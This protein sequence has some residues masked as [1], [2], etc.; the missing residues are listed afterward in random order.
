MFYNVINNSVK[1]TT[2]GEEVNV[3]SSLKHGVFSVTV[4]DTGRGMTESQLN[5]IFSRFKARS[6]N[7][8][9]GTG[10]GLAI[11]KSIA[12]FHSVE[13]SVSSQSGKGT[14]FSFIFKENS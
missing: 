14:I 11:T 13:V 5:N 8:S 4:S 10:I 9:D 3:I 7:E 12:D 2:K 1:N 6:G